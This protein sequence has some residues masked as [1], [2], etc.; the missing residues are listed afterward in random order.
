MEWGLFSSI[1]YSHM[2]SKICFRNVKSWFGLNCGCFFRSLWFD[3]LVLCCHDW[4]LLFWIDLAWFSLVG[5]AFFFGCC[6]EVDET[7]LK[8]FEAF[9]LTD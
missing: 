6:L 7:L 5:A 2:Q 1:H 8:G 3:W 9:D 4:L